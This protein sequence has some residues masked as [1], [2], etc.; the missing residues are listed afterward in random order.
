[1]RRKLEKGTLI[2]VAGPYSPL[3]D[4]SLHNASRTAQQNVDRAID[5]GI[6]L[7]K[8]GYIPLIPHL[9]HYIHLRMDQDLGDAWYKIDYKYLDVCPAI[10]LLNGWQQSFGACNERK[11]A[12][13]QNKII[14]TE[15][16]IEV[17]EKSR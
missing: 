13:L 6:R 16:D 9:S 8:L 7:L 14:L 3:K 17:M 12:F 4:C 1:M 2:Y 11:R 10:V 5:V 15:S